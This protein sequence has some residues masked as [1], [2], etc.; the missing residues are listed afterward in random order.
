MISGN[1]STDLFR[2]ASRGSSPLNGAVK[3]FL[4]SIITFVSLPLSFINILPHY[5]YSEMAMP[6]WRSITDNQI[7]KMTSTHKEYLSQR[8]FFLKSEV[9]ETT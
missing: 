2:V 8:E 5:I 3:D 4:L 1:F 7:R 9:E 6:I